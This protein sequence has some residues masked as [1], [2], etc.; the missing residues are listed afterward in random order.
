MLADNQTSLTRDH[1][2]ITLGFCAAVLL[3]AGLIGMM[4]RL[5]TRGATME[6]TLIAQRA[7][8]AEIKLEMAET[9]RA[10][11]GLAHDAAEIRAAIVH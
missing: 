9:R 3:C 5:Q 6:Q 10:A 1:R 11:Q 8:V 2:R 4:F 7:D